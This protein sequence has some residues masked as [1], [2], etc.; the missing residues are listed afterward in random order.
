[1]AD[2]KNFQWQRSAENAN[3]ADRP[4]SRSAK[5][6]LAL[7]QQL[8]GK[9]IARLSAPEQA[10]LALPVELR[11]ALDMYNKITDHEGRRRQLQFIGRLMRSL[12]TEEL[13][14]ALE[15]LKHR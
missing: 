14:Q 3:A 10:Q 1:M 7:S 8:L 4:P 2:K 11:D 5:K 12:D 13:E 6:R 15:R 9:R